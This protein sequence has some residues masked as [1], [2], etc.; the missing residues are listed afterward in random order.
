MKGLAGRIARNLWVL[1]LDILAVNAAYY[2][3]LVIR[4]STNLEIKPEAMDPFLPGY[5]HFAPFYTVICV[6]IFYLFR[7]YGGMWRYAGLNDMNR[8]IGANLV[9]AVIQVA[10]TL[11]FFQRMPISYYIIGAVLQFTFIVIIRFSYRFILAERQKIAGK[12]V[13]TVSTVVIG[14]GD[15]G[16]RAV[17]H[18]TDHTAFRVSVIYDERNAGMTQDGIRVVGGELAE[19]FQ[20]YD[21]IEA[22]CVA[23]TKLNAETKNTINK[24]CEDQGLELIDFTGKF[25]NLG[26]SLSLTALLEKAAGSVEIVVV[27]GSVDAIGSYTGRRDDKDAA[28]LAA[29]AVSTVYATGSEAMEAIK[30]R[31]EIISVS[32][33]AVGSGVDKSSQSTGSKDISELTDK[34]CLRIELKKP[35][36]DTAYDKWMQKY[37]EETGGE[38]SFF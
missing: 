20:A 35:T 17:Q 21:D 2:L 23:D 30:G 6:V 11:L 7:L 4:F 9:S 25:S 18:L 5:V 13:P 33:T 1:L 26:G 8:I 36:H 37:K 10:G 15:M 38:V 12:K 3:G 16:R 22:V 24:A 14:A 27:D 19:V 31:Y 32:A 28:G 29:G 34:P